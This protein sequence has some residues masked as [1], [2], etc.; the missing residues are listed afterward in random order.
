MYR[1]VF[2]CEDIIP[3]I[4]SHKCSLQGYVWAI[5][6]LSLYGDSRCPQTH[7]HTF[8]HS[9][10]PQGGGGTIWQKMW[11]GMDWLKETC[12]TTAHILLLHCVCVWTGAC[13][14]AAE[15]DTHILQECGNVC[16]RVCISREVCLPC[17]CECRHEHTDASISKANHFSTQPSQAAMSPSEWEK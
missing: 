16:G 8:T 9:F 6:E 12:I 15:P 11:A 5:S 7:T 4:L 14:S 2:S 3:A 17:E 10:Q 13:L 1:N